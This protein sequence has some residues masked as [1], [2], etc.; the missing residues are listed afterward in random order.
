MFSAVTKMENTDRAIDEDF[1]VEFVSVDVETD[2]VFHAELVTATQEYYEIRI[3]AEDVRVFE[4][5]T[6][7]VE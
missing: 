7:N 4:R 2:G 6:K 3:R 5:E 1:G